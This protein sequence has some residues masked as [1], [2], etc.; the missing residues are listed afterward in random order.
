MANQLWSQDQFS[1]GELSPY[2][3][4]RA[5]VAQYYNGLKTA[6]NVLCYPQG[7]AGKRFGTIYQA[8]LTN[9]TS[10]DAL[11][12]ETFQYLNQCTYQLVFR[13]AAI[14]IYLEGVLINSIT[15]TYDAQDLA[16]LDYT[17]LDARF[18]LTF[19]NGLPP[20]DL[21][22][23]TDANPQT[24]T[25]VST[26]SFQTT[27]APSAPFTAGLIYPVTF[28][29][30][31]GTMMQT[32]PQIKPGVTYFLYAQNTTTAEIY[33]TSQE[34]KNRIVT[35]VNAGFGVTSIGTG[36]TTVSVQNTWTLTPVVFKN[37]PTFDFDGGYDAI[38]FT[39]AAATGAA[40]TVTM[41]A[42]LTNMT[43]GVF[44]GGVFTGNGGYGRITS[45]TDTSHFVIAIEKPFDTAA[46]IAGNLCYLGEPA[47]GPTRGYP[48]KCSSFQNRSLFAN[49]ASLPNGFWASAINDYSDFDDMQTDDDDAISWYPTSNEINYIRFIVPYR[50]LTVHTNSGVYSSSVSVSS[51]ITP[52]NFSLQLQDST[53]ATNI[54]PRSIDN[55]IIVISGNDVH[56]LL[57]DG[58]NN[59]YTSDI[60]SVMSEQVIR[61]P[62]NEATYV[63]LNRAG[64]RYV[65]IINENGSMA[66]Y[67]SLISQ[68]VQGWTPNITEQSYGESKFRKVASTFDGR[69]WF[70]T[71][72]EIATA[73]APVSF[74]T[75][76]PTPPATGTTVFTAPTHL[77]VTGVVTAIKFATTGTLMTTTPQVVEGNYYWA[78]GIDANTFYA[79]ATKA[80]AEEN[81]NP[82]TVNLV[83]ANNTLEAWPLTTKFYLEE[84]SFD[85]HLDCATYFN[86][87]TAASTITSQSRFNAQQVKM[88][89]D[90][91][92]FSAQGNNNEVTFNAH[93]DDVE[94]TEGYIGFP[95]NTIIEP[96]P[97][98]MATGQNIKSTSLTEPKHIRYA[99]FM[100]NNTIGGTIN[101]YP[102][103]LKSFAQ[104]GIGEPPI[105]GRGVMEMSI[106]KA[107]DDFNNPSF[108]IEHNEPFNIELLGVF[109]TVDV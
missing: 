103:S 52:K 99:R 75:Y 51:A 11:F 96:M 108:T 73:S 68:D 88:V 97:L 64:S 19:E 102:I 39:P 2:M 33:A 24:V 44:T 98:S 15:S 67:Q 27:A 48:K 7:A 71:E 10:A 8:E 78:V 46:A 59:A 17:V 86:N 28:T 13:P 32:T 60:V 22:R 50:S 31:G 18:R 69:A 80:D 29:V 55:Q 26:V 14:D 58:I 84:L 38:T 25:S 79:Y 107:W 65:F 87:A 94:V 12:F 5:G 90:G 23:S 92:G 45:V 82:I 76:T 49:N 40:V 37:V 85:S 109:Y 56:N 101:G 93:G 95:I 47:W 89:G 70:V 77:L 35:G 36:T 20:T 6:Q 105:P 54:Q 57:W 63:D 83:P 30:A 41:S 34:A 106:M 3:Y 21:V 1:K 91:F 16:N 61:N 72:R 42:A 9:V 53:P 62:V 66:I 43:T 4:A 74:S 100:F 104:A 81:T